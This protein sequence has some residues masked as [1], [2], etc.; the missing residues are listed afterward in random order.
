ASGELSIVVMARPS[1]CPLRMT[2]HYRVTRAK[3]CQRN[4]QQ[5]YRPREAMRAGRPLEFQPRR[6]VPE[7][8]EKTDLSIPSVGSRYRCRALMPLSAVAAP[9]AIMK[10]LK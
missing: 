4:T 3:F 5:S 1:P 2:I 7:L 9:V 10:R 6:L 8:R